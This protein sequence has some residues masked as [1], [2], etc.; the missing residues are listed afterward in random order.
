VSFVCSSATLPLKRAKLPTALLPHTET[1]FC[2]IEVLTAPKYFK[3]SKKRRDPKKI[4]DPKNHPV[5]LMD[6]CV[7]N[8]TMKRDIY[9]LFKCF[10]RGFLFVP[11]SFFKSPSMEV[12]VFLPHVFTTYF[13]LVLKY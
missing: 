12:P 1:L 2:Q 3:K 13:K 6:R 8:V 5:I 10:V 9:P 11:I 4:S 7:T